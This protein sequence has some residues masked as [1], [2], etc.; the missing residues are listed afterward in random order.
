MAKLGQRGSPVSIGEIRSE[1]RSRLDGHR[2]EIERLAQLR[3]HGVADPGEASD[4]QYSEG[5]RA[6]ISAALDYGLDA[7]EHGEERAP[8][9]PPVL[10]AQARVAARSRVSLDTVLRRYFAGYTLLGDFLIGA[11][12]REGL[13]EGPALKSLLR[14]QATLFE[15]LLAAVSE[16][17]AGETERRIR[18][19]E[20]RRTQRVERLLAGDLID[21]SGFAYDFDGQHLGVVVSGPQAEQLLQELLVRADG[22]ILR[23]RR[24]EE[25]WA[26][27][28]GRGCPNPDELVRQTSTSPSNASLAVGEPGEGRH[29]WRLTHRQAKAA[30]PLALLGSTR[31]VRYREVA[32]PAA[33]LREDLLADSLHQLYLAPLACERD[34]GAIAR[35]TLRAYFAT[36]RNVSSAAAVLKVNRRTVTNR[37]RMLE[38]RIGRSLDECAVDFEIALRMDELNSG[39]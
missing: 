23:A 26:W 39:R 9:I 4:P 33:V 12:S 6:A 14:G 21:T 38:E 16:E 36:G 28:G 35:E 22:R 31:A 20:Q 27:I 2:A 5:L 1:V 34:G 15:R 30:L 3:A 8:E 10:L 32:L 7:I 29:G 25:L 11:A 24:G 18:S 37:L 13:V 19:V 17:Y